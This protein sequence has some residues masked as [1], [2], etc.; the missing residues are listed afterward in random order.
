[1]ARR[2]LPLTLCGLLVGLGMCVLTLCVLALLVRNLAAAE[3]DEQLIVNIG[4]VVPLKKEASPMEVFR[5]TDE[6]QV[7]LEIDPLTSHGHPARLAGSVS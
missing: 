6:E 4:A 7:P 5:L 1:M 3:D 2:T